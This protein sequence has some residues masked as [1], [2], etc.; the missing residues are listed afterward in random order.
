MKAVVTREVYEV[1]ELT[2][3][4]GMCLLTRAGEVVPLPPKTFELFV[5]LV[6]RA[7]GIVRRQELIDHVWPNEIVNDEALT[8]R[9]LLLRR[10]LGDDPKTPRYIA[11]MPRWGY[12]VVAAVRRLSETE[13]PAREHASRFVVLHEDRVFAL[14]EGETVIGRDSDVGVSIDSLQISRHHA[15]IVVT[16]ERAVLE[17][18][19]SKNGSLLNGKRISGATELSDGDRIGIGHEVLVFRFRDRLATTLTD[20]S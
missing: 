19:G 17:D 10:A 15:R 3:D 7:P 1:G 13:K 8:Q 14:P 18:L 20:S 11:S 9:M 6:R 16:E 12:R 5:E 2:L 4:V